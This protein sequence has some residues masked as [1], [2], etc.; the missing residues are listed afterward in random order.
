MLILLNVFI[1]M[2]CRG[3]LAGLNE[4]L[5]GLERKIEYLEARVREHKLLYNASIN[6]VRTL[7]LICV[8]VFY[9]RL[10]KETP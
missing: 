2:S 9:F 8:V 7:F 3:R 5:T 10:P 6:Y 1:D 4:K